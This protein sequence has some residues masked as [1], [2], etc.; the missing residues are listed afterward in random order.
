MSKKNRPPVDFPGL[1]DLEAEGGPLPGSS[2][3]AH[4]LSPVDQG[5]ADEG[6]LMASDYPLTAIEPDFYQGRGGVLPRRLTFEV[7]H[8]SIGH[9][10]ALEGWINGLVEGTPEHEEYL[11]LVGLKESIRSV[12][13]L[14]PIHISLVHDGNF[15]TFR[16]PQCVVKSKGQI[17]NPLK[18]R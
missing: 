11:Q 17:V 6:G 16:I 4:Y 8:K 14:H 5:R 2:A 7:L 10:E 1:D 15:T 9:L 18:R 13:L 3:E 12:G